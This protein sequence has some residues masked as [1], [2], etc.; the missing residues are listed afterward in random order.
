MEKRFEESFNDIG[1]IYENYFVKKASGQKDHKGNGPGFRKGAMNGM[2]GGSL[3]QYNANQGLNNITDPVEGEEAPEEAPEEDPII[4]KL[5]ELQN[6]IVI[7]Y[8]LLFL[9]ASCSIYRRICLC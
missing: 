8:T 6:I 9:R 3:N 7:V 2:P 5:E 1:L 4:V